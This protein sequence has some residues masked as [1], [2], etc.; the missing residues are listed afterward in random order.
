MAVIATPANWAPNGTVTLSGSIVSNRVLTVLTDDGSGNATI[1]DGVALLYS[2]PDRPDTIIA[3]A[4][5]ADT[6]DLTKIQLIVRVSDTLTQNMTFTGS[7][8]LR[9]WLVG[10]F[11]ADTLTG[12]DR[13]DTLHGNAGN[14]IIDGGAGHDTL[15]GGAGNDDITGGTGTD[16]IDGAAGVFDYAR[17]SSRTGAVV[18]TLNG[19]TAATV[20]IGGV[21]EDTIRNIEAVTGGNAGDTLTGDALANILEG[22]AGNDTLIGGGNND[23]LTGDFGAETGVDIINGGPGDDIIEGGAGNDTIDGGTETDTAS[24]F[25]EDDA[26]VVTLNGATNARVFVGGV[27]EDTIRNIE[28]LIGG[29]GNDILTGDARPNIFNPQDGTDT[30]NGR[31]GNDDIFGGLGNDTFD[32]GTE[33]DTVDYRSAPGA[34]VV[35]LNGA[36]NVR[37][38]IGGVLDDTIRNIEGVLGGESNDNLG[39]DARANRLDGNGGRDTLNG[40]GGADMMSG[41]GGRD[42]FRFDST[43]GATN[44]DTLPDFV[45]I[46]DTIE[47]DNAKLVGLTVGVLNADA[48]H[49]GTAAADAED[50]I[51]YDRGIGAL[52]FDPDGNAAGRAI[53]F[54]DLSNRPTLTNLDFVVV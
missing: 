51:I 4:L 44:I 7:T 6:I 11:G 39:G 29:R 50:R 40:R 31:A 35:S 10:G 27:A 43:L 17:Y 22:R 26:V 3:T 18:V 16:T 9:N 21:A 45:S 33:V 34:V 41:G 19:A 8:A 15:G 46:D 52:S 47:I 12:G 2:D 42:T 28:N 23:V 53:Q 49:V 32:G 38:S 30:V 20:T 24:Y 1:R 54:A 48:F 25:F 13:N 5:S 37:V 36:G 14:D